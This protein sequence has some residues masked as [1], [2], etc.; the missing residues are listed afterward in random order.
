MFTH[1]HQ[2]ACLSSPSIKSLSSHQAPLLAEW[3]E[4]QRRWPVH[5]D[6]HWASQIYTTL[7]L[8]C[9][10][11]PPHHHRPPTQKP[12]TSG[13]LGNQN[14]KPRSML[15]NNPKLISYLAWCP[16]LTWFCIPSANLTPAGPGWWWLM[17]C[18]VLLGPLNVWVLLFYQTWIPKVT[19][20]H[21]VQRDLNGAECCAPLFPLQTFTHRPGCKLS[22]LRSS[23]IK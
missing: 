3:W 16:F 4:S 22:V 7:M 2:R 6:Q 18:F 5:T 9:P 21:R 13:L 11:R 17:L 1:R 8:L 19:T 15:Q 14:P 23:I 20:I 12:L 10:P